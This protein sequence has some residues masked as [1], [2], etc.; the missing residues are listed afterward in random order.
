MWLPKKPPPSGLCVCLRG[1]WTK[2]LNIH[3]ENSPWKKSALLYAHTSRAPQARQQPGVFPETRVCTQVCVRRCHQKKEEVY[4]NCE[5]VG[6]KSGTQTGLQRKN[7]NRQDWEIRNT[8]K[9]DV[10]LEIVSNVPILVLNSEKLLV[11]QETKTT[12]AGCSQACK[13]PATAHV[14]RK[15]SKMRCRD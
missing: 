1:Q 6:V 15:I 8:H 10:P 12:E 5:R 13:A 7:R 9:G 4:R 14:A 3:V 11:P 2:A